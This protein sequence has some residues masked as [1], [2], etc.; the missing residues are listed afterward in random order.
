M[1]PI[2]RNKPITFKVKNIF[3]SFTTNSFSVINYN[4]VTIKKINLSNKQ[5]F[6]SIQKHSTYSIK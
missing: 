4:Q 2:N 5:H 3:P 1:R 6:K